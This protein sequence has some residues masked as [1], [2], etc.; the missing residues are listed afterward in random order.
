M[1]QTVF[2]VA[3]VF[4]L[5][6]ILNMSPTTN[7]LVVCI[8][9][10]YSGISSIL[11]IC[12]SKTYYILSGMDLDKDLKLTKSYPNR[13]GRAGIAPMTDHKLMEVDSKAKFRVNNEDNIR[14]QAKKALHGLSVEE[15]L[16]RC[17]DEINIWQE[18]VLNINTSSNSNQKSSSM[19]GRDNSNVVVLGAPSP[20]SA[21]QK[22]ISQDM[23]AG[24]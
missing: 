3:F 22:E 14:V 20:M 16:L 4:P 21:I 24:L 23:K 15:K 5:V 1:I 11:I 9:F 8:A 7:Q 18:M 10:A 6:F 13:L 17:H 2:L 12:G 19:P